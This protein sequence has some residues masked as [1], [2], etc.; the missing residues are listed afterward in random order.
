MRILCFSDLHGQIE[1]LKLLIK[2]AKTQEFDV[3]LIAGDLTNADL[4]SPRMRVKHARIVFDLLEGL[5]IPYYFVWGL[6]FRES[7]IA[8]ALRLWRKKDEYAEVSEKGD[9][10]FLVKGK[11]RGT[12]SKWSL[13]IGE[14]M[15]SLLSALSYGKCLNDIES[16]KLDPY[17]LT[18]NPKL[19][20]RNTIFLAHCYRKPLPALIQLDG[21]VHYGQR[22][23][24][25]INLGFL[26]RD[27]VHNAPSIVGCY[28]ILEFHGYE[29][30]TQW[31]DLGRKLKEYTCPVH[32]EEG[33]FYIPQ[34]WRKCP[35]CFDEKNAIF[36]G[37]N[38]G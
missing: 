22:C 7:S 12:V 18:C 6:P 14:Q 16:E 36:S 9:R 10:V 30:S 8:H 5:K 31:I 27:A 17:K 15:E 35:V 4:E 32:S 20:D 23:K 28:W 37:H 1:A 19:V 33:V 21:H 3:I 26:F 25:Y 34:Y 24:N 13:R 38:T 2:D 29:V 11:S